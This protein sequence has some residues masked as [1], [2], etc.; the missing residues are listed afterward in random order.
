MEKYVESS[1]SFKKWA[2][3]KYVFCE[4]T[5]YVDFTEFFPFLICQKGVE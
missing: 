3:A 1:A 5:V 4:K 2:K